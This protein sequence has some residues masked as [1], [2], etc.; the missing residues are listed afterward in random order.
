M[1]PGTSIHMVYEDTKE[2]AI[3]LRERCEALL[4]RAFESL[5]KSLLNGVNVETVS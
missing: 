3:V 4:R 1:L 2:N 5:S